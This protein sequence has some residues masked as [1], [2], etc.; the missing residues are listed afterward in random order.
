M[1]SRHA[2]NRLDSFARRTHRKPQSFIRVQRPKYGQKPRLIR[3]SIRQKIVYGTSQINPDLN[4]KP[5]PV[6][7]ISSS[8]NSTNTITHNYNNNAAA[9]STTVTNKHPVIEV[10]SLIPNPTPDSGP[11]STPIVSATITS[12]PVAGSPLLGATISYGP[13]PTLF[14]SA[15]RSGPHI[16]TSLSTFSALPPLLSVLTPASTIES[17][18]GDSFLV[19]PSPSVTGTDFVTPPS[20]TD[21]KSALASSRPIS[22]PAIVLL[23]VGSGL[24]LLGLCIILKMCTGP[25]RASRPTPSLPILKS[26]TGDDFFE[27]KESPIFGG[28]ERL[29][30]LPGCNGPVWAWIQYPAT[31]SKSSNSL[32]TNIPQARRASQQSFYPVSESYAARRASINTTIM[33]PI[34]EKDETRSFEFTSHG[35]KDSFSSSDIPTP[36]AYSSDKRSSAISIAPNYSVQPEYANT[37]Q[38]SKRSSLYRGDIK[39]ARSKQSVRRKSQAMDDIKA[40]RESTASFMGLAYDDSPDPVQ[41]E[42]VDPALLDKE[43]PSHPRIKSGYFS[44]GGYNHRLSTVGNTGY[45]IATATRV[46]VGQRNSYT[47]DKNALVDQWTNAKRQRD[48][49]ALTYALGLSTPKTEYV[50]SSPQPTLYPDDSMSVVEGE[51]AKK[52]S[53]R[54]RKVVESTPD[55]PSTSSGNLMGMQFGVSQMSLSGLALQR[56]DEALIGRNGDNVGAGGHLRHM[57]AGMLMPQS[58]RNTDKP[59][60]VPSPPALPSLTQMGL[61]HN[62][63]EAYANYRSPTYS[64]Y[65][66]YEGDR[67]SRH[68]MR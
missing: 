11:I 38:T 4:E 54:E 52:K 63:P 5:I 64:I 8:G 15:T 56:S 49:Q 10:A 24:L 46:N 43:E 25:R 28:A 68:I 29:S 32:S 23:A 47:K 66:F 48:T 55:M 44:G 7:K 31:M 19:N 58:H 34:P 50:V 65:G 45:S 2:K 33:H 20:D 36:I 27:G 14:S 3:R 37:A 12:T 18:P 67:K 60:R 35:E 22:L 21:D 39:R 40:R 57:D 17:Q 41:T 13:T 53:P 61:E 9:K 16:I 6:L 1:T 59:P 62:N 30:P 26:D 42:T 51:R